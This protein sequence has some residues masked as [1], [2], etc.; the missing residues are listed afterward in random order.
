MTTFITFSDFTCHACGIYERGIV[1]GRSKIGPGSLLQGGGGWGR[2][3]AGGG[4]RSPGMALK[5]L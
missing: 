2:G 1:G 5:D 4:G 3:G